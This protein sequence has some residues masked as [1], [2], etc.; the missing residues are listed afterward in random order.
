MSCILVHSTLH[1]LWMRIPRRRTLIGSVALLLLAIGAFS[2]AALLRAH[3]ALRQAQEAVSEE[4]NLKFVARPYAP[5]ADR[6]FEWLGSSAQFSQAAEFE[7]HLF[8]AGQT[9]LFEYDESGHELREFRAG[10]DLPP[11]QL[12][13]IA[14]ATLSDYQQP[15]LVIATADAGALVFD[16]ARFRQILPRDRD[17]RSLTSIL[18]LASGEILL[19][20]SK[21]GVLVYDG[22]S[23]RSFHSTLAD[24]HVTELTG[25]ESDLWIGTQDQGVGHWHGGSVEWFSESDG[26]PDARVY[27]I[28]T[29]GQQTFV[30]TPNGIAEFDNGRFLRRLVVGMFV[31][32]LL[33]KDK[34]LLAGTMDDGI[35]EIPLVQ[36]SR[37]QRS[38]ASS[39]DLM[40]VVQLFQSS[41]STY[42]LTRTG[43]SARN[44]T[45]SWKS[46]LEPDA[47]LL[48]D[49]NIS[50]LAADA[51]GRLWVGYFDHGLDIVENI[52]LEQRRSTRHIEDDHLFCINRILPNARSETT[53]VATAN[54]LVLF[55]GAG[56]RRQV[57]T[58]ADGLIADH[59][60][61]IASYG[62]GMVAATPAGLT[63][64]DADGLR[65]IYAF[66]GLVNNHVYA[67]AADGRHLLAGTL[68]GASLL[69]DDQVRVSYTTAT[70]TLKHNW[71][72]TALHVGDDWWLG[73]YGAGVMR[74]ND[75]EV[76]RFEPANG[77][78]ADLIVNPGAM[79]A[80]DHMILA[81][82]M[83]NGLYVMDR[84]GERWMAISD[85]LP[86][87]NVTAVAA[88]NGYVYIGTDNGL[89]RIS[90][91]SLL[92]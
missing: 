56:I 78:G 74:M 86:S 33:V 24:V 21:R 52:D 15:E 49:G 64:I 63:F 54:G 88:A 37:P 2:A 82:T 3:H 50:A 65:S 83:G 59:V 53:A 70:S 57:L 43:I 77:A 13:R 36:S 6:G 90:E 79:L 40:E 42:A 23:L 71:I 5:M 58:R 38:P 17:A 1:K 11:S 92:Q 29:S 8:V 41:S 73:T 85:G 39:A 55:D 19:G 26:L 81:G 14:R 45:A 62:G 35:V 46:V 30:G 32:S 4:S 60:T 89:V 10:R 51:R 22:H 75:K 80:T 47:R 44:G 34:T 9:G 48:S 69:D 20:T 91:R 12:L 68:G 7:G 31:R 84:N 27:V 28:A 87:M 16:G 18:P 66:Q 61:D 72:T 67:L 25:T 76:G